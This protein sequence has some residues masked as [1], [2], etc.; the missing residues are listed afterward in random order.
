MTVDLLRA[1][2]DAS[3]L[4]VSAFAREVLVVDPSTV[5]RWLA[6]KPMPHT[7]VARLERLVGKPQGENPTNPITP[8]LF[9][10]PTASP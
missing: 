4:S 2:I 10:G 8:P 3:G 5:F 1:A 9:P 6:G 7:V